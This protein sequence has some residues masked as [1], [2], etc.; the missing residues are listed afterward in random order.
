MIKKTFNI[1]LSGVQFVIDD[2]AYTLAN[3]YLDAIE[4]LIHDPEERSEL[5]SD[6]ENRM[7]ELLSMYLEEKNATIVS[8]P[9][10]ES[11]ISRIGQPNDF[12][13][14]EPEIEEKPEHK[15]SSESMY[16]R[17]T[18]PPYST[19]ASVKVRRRLFRDP[20]NAI[21]GGVCA[22]ISHYLNID[23]IWIRL[24]FVL[25]A[26]GAL[27]IASFTTMFFIYILLWIII[28]PAET[29]AQ[30]MQMM[31]E[32]PT[33]GN[34]ARTVTSDN[35]G[36]DMDS[37]GENRSFIQRLTKVL[38]NIGKGIMLFFGVVAVPVSIGL[39]V[40]ILSII[41]ALIMFATG[42]YLGLDALPDRET[43]LGLWTA[44]G[45][46]VTVLIPSFLCIWYLIKTIKPSAQMSRTCGIILAILW[47]LAFI[48]TSVCV[49]LLGWGGDLNTLIA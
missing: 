23:P 14:A 22:G 17:Q 48:F 37:E 20:K 12:I 10:V 34:I 31:G 8:L 11:V 2:D 38:Q 16:Q 45:V 32:A 1:N 18:P 49:A 35:S 36:A 44:L 7:A 42:N 4:H 6:I 46:C 3:N 41:F 26:L 25:I 28:P 5:I 27:N 13:E 30:R 21:F 24:I 15:T 47:T 9:M 29:P 33:L 43:M 19:P 39:V 40:G